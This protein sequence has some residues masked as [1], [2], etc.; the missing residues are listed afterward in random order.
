MDSDLHS[1]GRQPQCVREWWRFC[2]TVLGVGAGTWGED[3]KARRGL[4]L[5]SRRT[6]GRT[7][8]CG[9]TRG[10][11]QGMESWFLRDT[12]WR[13]ALRDHLIAGFDMLD[14]CCSSG[15]NC[16][17]SRNDTPFRGYENTM[18]SSTRSCFRACMS[19]M[20]VERGTLNV[21]RETRDLRKPISKH[22]KYDFE[23][24]GRKREQTWTNSR[25]HGEEKRTYPSLISFPEI[26][27]PTAPC[28]CDSSGRQ[29]L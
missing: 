26:D 25:D 19:T 28:L 8:H 24:G 3:K 18:D 12:R 14:S 20:Q 22:S 13:G 2:S 7:L 27:L 29:Q 11:G 4:E 10:S 16:T 1:E 5:G 23:N 17:H 15:Q 6:R 21:E 9:R